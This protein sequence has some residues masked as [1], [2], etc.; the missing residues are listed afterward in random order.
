MFVREEKMYNKFSRFLNRGLMDVLNKSNNRERAN[1]RQTDRQRQGERETAKG[2]ERY[3]QTDRQGER[4]REGEREKEG[5]VIER[6]T[7][8]D[9]KIQ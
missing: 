3:R 8:R 6:E 7:E 1:G 4:D 2:R 5:G 9:G